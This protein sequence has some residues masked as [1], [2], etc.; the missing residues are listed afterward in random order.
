M[1]TPSS[2]T[3]RRLVSKTEPN[4]VSEAGSTT[5][6]QYPKPGKR[7]KMPS[8]DYHSNGTPQVMSEDEINQIIGSLS[9]P[10]PNTQVA[11]QYS[12][13]VSDTEVQAYAKLAGSV[14]TYYVQNI[15]V[16]I[17]RTSDP[18]SPQERV[19][20]DLGPAKV[21][22]RRHAIIQYNTKLRHWEIHIL[23]RNGVRVD[24]VH[25]KEGSVVLRSG[26]ILDIGGVQMM[27]VLPDEPP[28]IAFNPAI[29]NG[30]HKTH[31][32][33]SSV[34][35]HREVSGGDTQYLPQQTQQ[36]PT[37]QP[38]AQFSQYQPPQ[39]QQPIP[40]Q[41]A[42]PVEGSNSN[43]AV[44]YPKGVA[45]ITR[46]QVRGMAQGTQYQEQDL[47]SDDAK[48][49]KPPYS[50]ATMITQAI[51]S[52]EEMMMS[53]SE[54]YEWISTNYSFYRHSK[55]GWQNSIRHNLSLNKAFEKV[56]RKAN[57]PGK[58]KKW[59]ITP[60]FKEEFIRKANMGK[61]AKGSNSKR[62]ANNNLH[63]HQQVLHL[64]QP[65]SGPQQQPPPQQQQHHHL[66]PPP[67]PPPQQHMYQ[68]QQ[69]AFHAPPPPPPAPVQPPLPPPPIQYSDD[70]G[71]HPTLAG[72]T[73]SNA[74]I[75]DFQ[76]PQKQQQ[77]FQNA[78]GYADQ[79]N[80]LQFSNGPLP[81]MTP[82]PSRR[83][84]VSQLEAYTPD[85]G[86]QVNSSNNNDNDGQQNHNTNPNNPNNT[87]NGP[88]TN[89]NSTKKMSAFGP[90][91][92]NT[93]AP[94]AQH[95]QLAP[96]SSAQ[97]QQLPSSFM[98]A[99]SPAPFWKY[100][101]LSSTP[102]RNNDLSPTKF[103]SPPVGVG[104]TPK[105]PDQSTTPA[106][107]KSSERGDSLGDLHDV[108][109]TRGFGHIGKWRESDVSK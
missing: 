58:G 51:L 7:R 80:Y 52:T 6:P 55:S 107:E 93:P 72:S 62:N 92:N 105:K 46:P 66:P 35:P 12:N 30:H 50:Y 5:P 45:I 44:S 84:P 22:S 38:E 54:I 77:N 68:Q 49:I 43:N 14:W 32:S 3:K 10:D 4:E 48:D 109:L 63:Q 37:P 100:M 23:G 87:T 89:G 27:F 106:N 79:Y 19:D 41:T 88:N 39:Q 53:L 29:K 26:N 99:S 21:V 20:I 76:T 65:A 2:P 73:S 18:N 83:Y 47:S 9:L 42:P 108:D 96:P 13:S 8:V 33:V 61:L 94:Q 15:E 31:S 74:T 1:S 59:Q 57:E 34:S 69:Q 40:E 78:S 86:S 24:R 81:T 97:Q 75:A 36:A 71:P 104:P 25:Y 103:S 90:L 82:S 70:Q 16:V 11:V 56:P 102:I 91:V 95:L 17:G 85:R 28:R 60:Q 67:P 101:Q 98:P 64:S